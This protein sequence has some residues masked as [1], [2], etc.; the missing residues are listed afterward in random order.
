MRRI[1]QPASGNRLTDHAALLERLHGVRGL[2]QVAQEL[3]GLD[4][5][6]FFDELL[7]STEELP[8]A[9]LLAAFGVES[10]LRAPVSDA[11]AGGRVS[12]EAPG[13]WAGLKLRGGETRIAYI[14]AGSPAAQAGLSVNDQLLAIDGLRVAPGNWPALLGALP[15]G[16]PVTL[17]FFRGDEL[18]EATLLPVPPPADTWTLTL[19]AA[20]GEVLA[21]RI[22]WLGM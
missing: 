13:A 19:A 15:P 4:L 10:K 8:L 17:H 16:Q 18:L 7:R 1:V 11:D 14:Q 3:S 22:A 20:E 5:G 21:R 12:G 9:E 2:E 6:G